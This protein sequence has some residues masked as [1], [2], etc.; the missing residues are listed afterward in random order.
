MM[1]L[2]D[3]VTPGLFSI[4]SKTTARSAAIGRVDKM[5]RSWSRDDASS[6]PRF[7]PGHVALLEDFHCPV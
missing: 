1:A 6:T 4:T 2:K 5:E 3:Q 7:L